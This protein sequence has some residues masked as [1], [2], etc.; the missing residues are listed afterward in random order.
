MLLLQKPETMHWSS[1][2]NNGQLQSPESNLINITPKHL[3]HTLEFLKLPPISVMS[4]Y[5]NYSCLLI[6]VTLAYHFLYIGAYLAITLYFL[7]LVAVFNLE[8]LT[9]TQKMSLYIQSI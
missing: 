9:L 4:D 6:Y 1:N 3:V 7:E 2:K 5:F 8:L